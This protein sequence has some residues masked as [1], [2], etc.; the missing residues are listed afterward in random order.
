MFSAT[1]RKRV[2]R[3]ARAILSD[4]IRVVQGD[5]GEV[6]ILVKPRPVSDCRHCVVVCMSDCFLSTHLSVRANYQSLKGILGRGK[7]FFWVSFIFPCGIYCGFGNFR[8]FR[9]RKFVI[10]G[11]FMNL[12][13]IIFDDSSAIIIIISQICPPRKIREK[14][15]TSR[16]LLDLQ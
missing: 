15:K 13:I 1:F 3:V 16:I 9:F 10:L 7:L 8:V 11:L 12:R 2:E 5:V 14:I 6:N 4:P